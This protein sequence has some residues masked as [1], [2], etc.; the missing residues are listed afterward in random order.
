VAPAG[1]GS[2]GLQ[3]HAFLAAGDAAVVAS[4]G[5]MT[6]NFGQEAIPG[7]RG[8]LHGA[9]RKK[10]RLSSFLAKRRWKYSICSTHRPNI[11][12]HTFFQKD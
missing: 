11:S 10:N 9:G 6:A 12:Q 4:P 1:E 2:G 5:L 8:E 3:E 7:G